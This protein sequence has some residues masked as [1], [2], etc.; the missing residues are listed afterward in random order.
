MSMK[1]FTTYRQGDALVAVAQ[2]TVGSLGAADAR[3]EV[4]ALLAQIHE[5]GLQK[6]V[7]DMGKADYFGSQMIELMIIAWRRL[8]S[9]HGILALCQLSETGRE[10]M[11]TVG[12]D[13]LW[14]VCNTLDEALAAQEIAQPC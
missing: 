6:L 1:L 11:H 13:K 5:W 10:V 3:F 7:F 8:A 14:P 2:G 12:L 9:D 4:D